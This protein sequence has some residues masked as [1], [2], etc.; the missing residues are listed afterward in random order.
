MFVPTVLILDVV[1]TS[2][3]A[4]LDQAADL[5]GFYKG[6]SRG[7]STPEF[8]GFTS[9]GRYLEPKLHIQ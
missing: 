1:S 3:G 4:P 2:P 9:Q 6:I 7:Q 5:F 8:P